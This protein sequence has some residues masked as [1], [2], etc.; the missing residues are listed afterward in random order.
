MIDTDENV[1]STGEPMTIVIKNQEGEEVH[2]EV[3]DDM[4]FSKANLISYHSLKI[5][6]C[7]SDFL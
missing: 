6:M 3:P 1:M 5:Y 7:I 2:C 4:P